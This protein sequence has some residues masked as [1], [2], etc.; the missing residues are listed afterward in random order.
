MRRLFKEVFKSLA[1]NKVTLICL[2]ILIFLT[3]FL[4]TLLNDVKTTY[5]RTINSY[6][7]VS[8]LHDLTADLDI[9]PSG[10][11]PKGGFNQI[12][13]DNQKELKEPIKFES[14]KN[15]S[16][17]SYSLSLLEKDRQFIK[18]KNKFENW[19]ISDDNY[20]I[21]T[22]DFMNFFYEKKFNNTSSAEFE[23]LKENPNF[24]NIRDFKFSGNNRHFKLYQKIG[25]KFQQITEEKAANVSDSFT[26]KKTVTLN[27]ILN[28]GFAPRDSHGLLINGK[29]D[30][31][32]ASSPLYLNIETKEA[33]FSNVDYNQ[34]KQ[35]GKLAI[36]SA[37]DVLKILGFE[38]DANGNKWY[39]NSTSATKDI[40]F[41]S[42]HQTT[43][44]KIDSTTKL[45][46][47]FKLTHYLSTNQIKVSTPKFVELEAN[48][49]YKLP[50]DWIRK[51]EILTT[52]NWYRFIL[53]WD[54]IADE[55]K[56]NWKGSYYKF[57][58]HLKQTNP[59]KYKEISYFS[60]WNKTVTTK[61]QIGDGKQ[62]VHSQ[63]LAIEKQD[64]ITPFSNPWTGGNANKKI[65]NDKSNLSH[66]N[67]NNIKQVEFSRTGADDI[68]DNEFAQISDLSKLKLHQDFIRTNSI[69]Y[70]RTAIINDLKKLVGEENLGLRQTLTVETVNEETSKKNVFHFVNSGD[71][72]RKI[73]G[74]EQNVGKLYNE[75]LNPGYLNKSIQD[76]NV[77]NF[78]LKPKLGDPNIQKIPSVYTRPLIDNIFKSFTP[79]VNYFN[80]D[81]RFTNY[82]DFLPKTKIPYLINGKILVITT[83]KSEPKNPNGAQIIGA[84]AMP[85]PGKY[86]LL[87][88][89]QIEGFT[90]EKVWNK[91]IVD[92][93]ETMTLDE[94]YNYLILQDYTIRG[95]IGPNGWAQVN[96]IFKNSISLPISFGSISSELSQ[97]I[98]QK[99]TITG[100]I[101]RVRSII[102]KSDFGKLISKDDWYRLF[103]AISKSIESN[104]FHTLLAVAKTN[105]EILT[106]VIIDVL[107]YLNEPIDHS[108]NKNLEFTNM[109]TNTFIK[110]ILNGVIDYLEKQYIS[111]GE[112][113]EKRDAYLVEQINQLSSIL[114]FNTMFIIP[115]L[116]MTMSDLLNFIK[117]KSKI[118]AA[119]KG[120][121]NSFDFIK[122]STIAQ[123]WYRN[124]P[125]K[126]FTSTDQEYWSLSPSRIALMFLQS[127]DEYEFKNAL[128]LIIEQI[129]F[130]AI[131]DPNKNSSIYK[132]WLAAKDFA[133][134]KV[135]DED[136]A[137]ISSLFKKLNGDAHTPYKNINDGLFELISNMSLENFNESISKLITK[138]T[139][140]ITANGKIYKNYNTEVLDQ[141]DYL[142]AFL[143]SINSAGKINQIQNAF[144]KMF[145]LSKAT[146]KIIPGLNIAIPWKDDNKISIFDL[147]GLTGF[148][149]PKIQKKDNLK[150]NVSI[151]PYNIDDINIL[152]KKTQNAI[153]AKQNISLTSNEYDFVKNYVLADNFDFND[154]N[155]LK[156]KLL[157]YKEYVEKLII[158]KY[159]SESGNYNFAN[160]YVMPETYGDLAYSSA[161][162]NPTNETKNKDLLKLLHAGM[163]NVLAG[164]ML[165]S[166]NDIIRNELVLY[167][168][169]IKL[170]YHLNHLG[171]VREEIIL[172]KE[173]GE[174]YIEKKYNKYLSYDQIRIVLIKLFELGQDSEITAAM[175]NYDEVINQIQNIGLEKDGEQLLKASFAHTQAAKANRKIIELINGNKFN[176]YFN[177][178]KAAGISDKAI[179]GIKNILL[180][181]SNELVY[182][183]GYIAS[184]KQMPTRYITS[185]RTFLE[186]FIKSNSKGLL[187][188]LITSDYVFDLIY[189]QTI[190][191]S[192]LASHLSLLNVPRN[193]LNPFTF[194]SFPQIIAYYM[195]S[196][197]AN[198]GN[199]SYV[200]SKIFNNLYGVDIKDIKNEI[201]A[202]TQVFTR[203]IREVDSKSDAAVRLDVAQFNNLFNNV[204]KNKDGKDM[205]IFGLNIT[206]TLREALRKVIE[207]IVVSNVISYSDSGSYLAKVNYGYL[208]ANKKEVYRGDISEYLSNPYQ[209][210]LFISKLDEKYKVKINTQE[211]LIIGIENTADYLYPVV[212]EENIQVDV[213]TQAIVFVNAKGFDRIYSA[214][215]TFALKSYALIKSPT[216][217]KGKYLSGK[218]PKEL[219]KLINDVIDKVAPGTFKKVFLKDEQDSINPERYIRI[220]TI[221]S[222]VASIRN[223]TVWLITI[224]T[225]LVAFIVYFIIK[226]YI[227]A[228]NK[229]VGI[230]RAQGYKTSEI[231]FSF[232]AFGWIPAAVGGIFGYI[233]GFSLQRQAMGILASYWT[234]ESNII[235]FD[236]FSLL[237]TI[238]I[239]LLFVSILI[240]II[241]QI[242][243]RKKATELMNGLTEVAVGNFAQKISSMFRKLPIKLRY[244]ASLALN[245]FW[246]MFSL[247]LAFSTTSL[248]SMFFLSS[249]NV[250]NKTISK[251]YED[252]LYKFK[253]DLESPT[254]EGGPYVTYDKG[255]LPALLYVPNDLAGNSSSNGSQLDYDN[256]NFL[257]PGGS[258]NTDTVNK[259]YAPTVLTKSSLDILLD[260][261]VELSPWDITYANMPETQRARVAQIFKRVSL[262]MQNTQNLINTARLKTNDFYDLTNA[263]IEE[264]ICVRNIDK[265]VSDLKQ[266]KPE[267]LTNRTSFFYFIAPPYWETS[268]SADSKITEKFNYVEWDVEN[269]IYLKPKKVSTSRFREEYRNFLIN[270]YKKIDANDFFVSFGGVFWNKATNEKYT[271]ASTLING[272]E[273]RIYGYRKDSKFIKLT[274]E[275]GENLTHKLYDYDYKFD[276][277]E[278][279][280]II[281]NEVA[282]RKHK[283]KINSTFE[284][285]LLNH[286]DR[287]SHLALQQI[288][289]KTKYRFKVIGISQTY[290]NTEFTTRKDILDHILG[291][292]TLTNRLRNSRKF[293]LNNLINFDPK[294]KEKYQKEFNDK[295]EA[296][297][298]ILS[299]DKTPVQTIDTLTTYSSTGFWGALSSVDIASMTDHEVWNFFKRIF[300]SDSGLKY[301]S[302]FEHNINA[303]NEAH[304]ELSQKLVYKDILKKILG[305]VS[306]S[307]LS[308]YISK[309]FESLPEKHKI[310][311]RAILTKFYGTQP[312]AIY[313]KNIMYGASFDVNSKDIEAGFIAGISQTV[314]IILVAFIIISLLISIIILIAITNIMIASNQ[315]AIATFSVL[316]YSNKEKIF[317]F[318]FNFVPAILL[319]CLIMIPVT[320]SLIVLFNAF[321]MATS[322]VVLP[323][324]LHSSTII[325]S[326]VICLSVFIATSIATWKSLNKV[327]AVDALKGK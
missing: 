133:G 10:I 19:N 235:A 267:D 150:T 57:I 158:K 233:V 298:G 199:L 105:N 277:N 135:S 316:G 129:D 35:A 90:N 177:E 242:S 37:E 231:A 319:A 164:A 190:D 97:E 271:Y 39:Y 76:Q 300:I 265:F 191:A 153:T 278:D 275:K 250:F 324:V 44:E 241:T 100:L 203:D 159:A 185:L 45:E 218:S 66:D 131:L 27:T 22:E 182:N 192:A 71:K 198:N 104:D 149:L 253:L 116:R 272:K 240:Y 114:N 157:Q 225:L 119:L 106:K 80:A 308:D 229:V 31:V 15:G 82:Y 86:I 101:Q 173:T 197:D 3:T 95:E 56:S 176:Q 32:Y 220:V 48:K 58:A 21:S 280:P 154:L 7:K 187:N 55:K 69:N 41:A 326:V 219:Q 248:I 72:D 74:I 175:L 170:G 186:S 140:T 26:F 102:L 127:I 88:H 36:I 227:E 238:V 115:Q 293:E 40:N 284:V 65:P 113:V 87:K 323:L 132:K 259:P 327:K 148:S 23:L 124:H 303:Y 307:D 174:K 151:D 232:C 260:L 67:K 9:N 254:T 92:N 204:L 42:G 130:Q 20:Y 226:R 62:E 270:A 168:L 2:T 309:K 180:S 53:N 138:V 313:G 291:Y 314:N 200:V 142:A 207:P 103:D 126:P 311:A 184:S 63:I 321:M 144:I 234:L 156:S 194:M 252:R 251:T 11:V 215:P 268:P 288:A 281:L 52:Y 273:N 54:E 14:S 47:N 18:L 258:F 83:A 93:K 68:T 211:Y 98:I 305:N 24:A 299:N 266:G 247:F 210:Q 202:I 134:E 118:F 263:D 51:V 292:D 304:P 84:I 228:R 318:F 257:R 171:D 30:F 70:A 178:L 59:E 1:K 256:P 16:D 78:I 262:K 75:T 295:Y 244:I 81:I 17:I 310:T 122:F 109:N 297:N 312:N 205:I 33:S 276:S 188:P 213:N 274:N 49:T 189:K 315:R 139:S 34:W 209:M 296:F 123:E 5:S 243:V 320:L 108:N 4:F 163:G 94:L 325:L 201:L 107:K 245:N 214:Y 283:L 155:K 317:L 147:L 79:D 61:Y 167:S 110:N 290:I 322:Q 152:L 64:A 6:D 29:K 125:Y 112:T 43:N 216:D 302:V 73:W 221:R 224:L 50:K 255:D 121:V 264:I 169:W 8:R 85:Q 38:K 146:S 287:F 249:A 172:N 179:S 282:S 60:Y 223:A 77:E 91:A 181:N 117:D 230:L 120:I 137:K 239:P 306:D 279:I 165:K 269:Q 99:K 12:D 161:L 196:P 160:N 286:V 217:K 195:L 289:P 28:I 13:K 145:N 237:G 136:K 128:K 25:D 46:N 212:N 166:N 236:I 89:S 285:N 222:I 183:F 193:I 111:S 294:N 301:I 206:S 96:P 141:S 261:S 208:N 143:S 162:F 246:K